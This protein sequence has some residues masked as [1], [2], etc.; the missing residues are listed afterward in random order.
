MFNV[1]ASTIL[2]R[3]MSEAATPVFGARNK[4]IAVPVDEGFT[5]VMIDDQ[6][7]ELLVD[8]GSW[9]LIVIDGH[10]YEEKFGEVACG[11]PHSGCFFCPVDA[12]C[13]FD[14][15]QTVTTTFADDIVIER[16]FRT[17]RLVLAGNEVTRFVY[18][19]ARSTGNATERSAIGYFGLALRPPG[20]ER[21]ESPLY[22][23]S[24]LETLF[25]RNLI[26]H[27]SYTTR[28]NGNQD[29]PFL[30]GQVTLGDTIDESDLS[31]YMFPQWTDDGIHHRAFAAVSV[32][33]VEVL[34]PRRVARGD[35]PAKS[36]LDFSGRRT[37]QSAFRAQI[38][39]GFTGLYLLYPD[40]F[41]EIKK[42]LKR[43]LRRAG[44]KELIWGRNE[45][46]VAYVPEGVRPFLPV[47]RLR[48]GGGGNSIPISIFP[49][50]Y[51]LRTGQGYDVILAGHAAHGALGTPFFRAFSVH[52]DYSANR[53]GLLKV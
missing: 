43:A 13:D 7:V 41:E 10:W 52:V 20:S 51:C 12:P 23:R 36:F 11:K 42:K 27:L 40:L 19:I 1:V 25:Q 49:E 5:S 31:N 24:V 34:H 8:S 32:L 37:N 9:D 18:S 33:S 21:F 14:K 3:L 44:H 48:L 47:L 15:E 6:E 45:N 4:T 53:I 26:G 50:H 46:G 17:G 2:V 39:T 30:S 35:R 16:I 38:G 29:S 28:S 22:Q